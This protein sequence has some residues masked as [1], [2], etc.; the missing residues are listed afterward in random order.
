[1]LKKQKSQYNTQLRGKNEY[2]SHFKFNVSTN[3]YAQHMENIP[4]IIPHIIN[5]LNEKDK[6][7][8]QQPCKMSD[9]YNLLVS[10]ATSQL[11]DWLSSKQSS[12][13]Q[14]EV[15]LSNS[16]QHELIEAYSESS[17]TELRYPNSDEGSSVP[18]NP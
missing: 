1:M 3:I 4:S 9:K 10:E 17:S 15:K 14:L 2:T 18:S 8:T 16:D 13:H 6:T 12:V 7:W 5:P 11:D